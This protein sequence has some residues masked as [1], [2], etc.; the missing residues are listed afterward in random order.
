MFDL[1]L[2]DGRCKYGCGYHVGLEDMAIDKQ[3][4]E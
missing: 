3:K 4:N 2:V 1:A